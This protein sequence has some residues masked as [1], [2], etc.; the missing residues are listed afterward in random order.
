MCDSEHLPYVAIDLKIRVKTGFQQQNVNIICSDKREHNQKCEK[1]GKKGESRIKLFIIV[2]VIDQNQR[3]LFQLG[4]IY[5]REIGVVDQGH[6]RMYIYECN[7]QKQ[8]ANL[9]Y[10]K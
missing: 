4:K 8:N 6:Y 3:I 1:R 9:K 10:D 5:I 7:Y 2:K